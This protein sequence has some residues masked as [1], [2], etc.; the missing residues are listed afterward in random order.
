MELKLL[1]V[2]VNYY[3]EQDEVK[4]FKAVIVGESY[5]DIT[6]SIENYIDGDIFYLCIEE[7]QEG[8]I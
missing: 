1:K 3:D 7:V 8:E 2:T 5:T 6:A 4:S